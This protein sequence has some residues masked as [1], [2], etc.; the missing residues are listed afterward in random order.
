MTRAQPE[1]SSHAEVRGST[2]H[3]E[4][5]LTLL[6]AARR[7]LLEGGFD[8]LRV[9]AIVREAGKNKAAVKYHFGSKD[10]LILALVESLD[11]ERLESILKQL[12][13]S[14]QSASYPEILATRVAEHDEFL[15]FYD[16]LPHLLRDERLA[17]GLGDL[18]DWYRA[19][20]L[21]FVRPADP[22]EL[23]DEEEAD[24]LGHLLIAVVDGLAL[25]A[26]LH[27]DDRRVAGAVQLWGRLVDQFL[28]KEAA[29]T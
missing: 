4:P 6:A 2:D 18:Y 15:M 21:K 11:H 14:H 28:A 13:S 12:E 27:K 9:D 16:L 10:G 25:Q 20:H 24:A 1:A 19:T 23:L 17:P 3:S 5:A 7:L 22:V 8:A 26:L 29:T